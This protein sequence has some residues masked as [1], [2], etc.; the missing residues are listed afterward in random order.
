MS[1][2]LS[3]VA[4]LGSREN[5]SMPNV[6][7]G[8]WA[9]MLRESL[10]MLHIDLVSLMSLSNFLLSMTETKCNIKGIFCALVC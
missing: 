6:L 10:G 3:V 1:C 8:R 4:Y 9:R 2:T 5:A 7:W